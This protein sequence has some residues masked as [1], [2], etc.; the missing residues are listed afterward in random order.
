MGVVGETWRHW[1]SDERCTVLCLVQDMMCSARP[2]HGD[3]RSV[4]KLHSKQPS[5]LCC[6][7]SQ[8][9][10]PGVAAL[11]GHFVL[12]VD[13]KG[14]QCSQSFKASLQMFLLRERFH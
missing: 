13:V 5:A 7:Y 3:L 6:L 9:L 1:S 8:V 14:I 12:L 2:F 11:K 10:V 4:L